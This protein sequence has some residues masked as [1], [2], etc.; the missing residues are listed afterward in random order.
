MLR[1]ENIIVRSCE[2]CG[3]AAATEVKR[4][5]NSEWPMVSCDECAFVY[6]RKVPGY[7]ALVD[8]FAWEK[9]HAEESARRLTRLDGR[10]DAATRWRLKIGKAIDGLYQRHVIGGSGNVLDVGC[11]GNCRVDAG[12]TPFGIEISAEL[13]GQA[14]PQFRARGGDV[15]HGPAVD[16]FDAFAGISFDAI[17]MRSYLEHE[18][19]PR[20]VLEKAFQRL[21]PGGRIHLRLPNYATPNR[22]LMGRKWCGFRFPDHVNYFTGSSLRRLATSIGFRY[23]RQNGLSLFD[24]NL[25]VILT[26]PQS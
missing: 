26:R 9:T 3:A 15:F 8:E 20:S 25:V 11:G 1:R 14:V 17:L 22:L 18:E 7:V 19:R 12:P 13:A 10:L 6:L 24:D 23:Q 5:S 4:Y 16:G 21:K 2:V